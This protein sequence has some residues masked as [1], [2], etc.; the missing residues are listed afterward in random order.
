MRREEDVELI[1][2]AFL[3][4]SENFLDSGVTL[5]E[6][7]SVAMSS[8]ELTA[9][10]RHSNLSPTRRAII[11]PFILPAVCLAV[12][13]KL[14]TIDYLLNYAYYESRC[15]VANNYFVWEFT[16]PVSNC[17]FCRGV[18]SALILDANLT[19]EEFAP[20]AYSSR[21]MIVKSAASHWPAANVFDLKFFRNLYES[22]DG[23]YESVEE[24]CQF[25]HFKSNFA[26]LRQVLEMNEG[27]ALNR[28][29][30]DSWYVGWKNC[31]P[32]VL[33]ALNHFYRPPHFLPD[34]A[35]IPRTN[36]VFIGYDQ[37]AIMHVSIETYLAEIQ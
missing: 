12:I 23:A 22:I 13:I 35:E 5:E 10:S 30:E 36:Y 25:L 1:K 16:R 17:D 34:D 7:R 3:R 24:E 19:R 28:D 29:G 21:P 20:Y 26:E 27:R 33:E 11:L 15:L 9:T 2:A 4:V 14:G 37:G 6:L 8:K 18:K 32:Q 31:H